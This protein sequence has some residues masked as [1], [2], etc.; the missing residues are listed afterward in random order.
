MIRSF[1]FFVITVFFV[2]TLA[3]CVLVRGHH[4]GHI[5]PGQLK[6]L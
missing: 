1:V 4:H 3:G 2:S 5:P 6:K